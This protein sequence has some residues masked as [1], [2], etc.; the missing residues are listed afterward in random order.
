MLLKK[1][2]VIFISLLLTSGVFFSCS[3]DDEIKDSFVIAGIPDQKVSDLTRRYSGLTDYLSEELGVVVQYLPTT[4]YSATVT[5]FARGDVHMAWF[6]GLTGVQARLAVPGSRAI[7]QRLRDTQFHTVFIFNKNVDVSA[8]QDLKGLRF[9]FGS[10]SSTS[11][12]LMPRHFLYENGIDPDSDFDGPPIYSGSHDQTWLLVQGGAADA[13]ALSEA[14]WQKAL[15][16][17]KV[18]ESR[19]G[20]FYVTP[21]Y[22][23]YNWT[24]RPDVE[25]NF[26]D[27]FMDL[28]AD[29]ILRMDETDILE[30]FSAEKF[31]AS[32]NGNYAEIENVARDLGIL[33]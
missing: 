3:S 4:D 30:L 26:G 14:V 10:E 20:L 7:A 19:I 6:G 21:P 27:G 8:L 28:A 9:A 29:A 1:V 31:I 11:G 15:S 2:L 22:F 25:E 33:K 32:E 17:G 24:I 16:S 13:G 5:A 23:D 18:D 12:H